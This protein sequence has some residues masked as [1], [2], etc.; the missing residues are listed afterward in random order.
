MSYEDAIAGARSSGSELP[1]FGALAQRVADKRVEVQGT[2]QAERL[3][4]R[5]WLYIA[6]AA[7]LF[8]PADLL[9]R[10]WALEYQPTVEGVT[11]AGHGVLANAVLAA[12]SYLGPVA[13]ALAFAALTRRIISLPLTLA[14]AAAWLLIFAA[15]DWLP[16]SAAIAQHAARRWLP[17]RH[18]ERLAGTGGQEGQAG[19]EAE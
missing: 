8:I 4:A 1:E 7:F 18:P 10:S 19:I 13:L 3:K 2:D 12:L 5:R 16:N 14:S 11:A 15:V 9:L 17:S 6:A